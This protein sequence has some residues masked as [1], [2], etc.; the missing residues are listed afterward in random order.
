M[1]VMVG[2]GRGGRGARRGGP[3][4]GAL[5]SGHPCRWVQGSVCRVPPPCMFFLGFR[6]FNHPL[7]LM[8]TEP[9]PSQGAWSQSMSWCRALLMVPHVLRCVVF[10]GVRHPIWMRGILAFARAELMIL[11]GGMPWPP[12]AL[13]PTGLVP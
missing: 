3:W 1:G 12:V 2:T 6:L 10:S 9:G 7:A 4:A 8:V 5:G 13:L 11:G